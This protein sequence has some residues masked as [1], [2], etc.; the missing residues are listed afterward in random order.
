MEENRFKIVYTRKKLIIAVA[1]SSVLILIVL[2]ARLYLYLTDD[3][4]LSNITYEMPYQKE[5]QS[6]PLTALEEEKL[7]NILAQEF[8]YLGKGSQC[9]V[10]SSKDGRYV[11]KFFKF[12]H[13]RPHWI[14]QFLPSIDFLDSYK[15]ETICAQIAQI[16]GD[17]SCI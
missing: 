4:R 8:S 16:V 10:F 14:D 12:K 7:A 1:I 11:L 6:P 15:T 13:V 3:F 2:A 17:V 5:W 9:Y